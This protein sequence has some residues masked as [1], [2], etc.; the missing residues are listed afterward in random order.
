MTNLSC[1]AC[2]E[3]LMNLVKKFNAH[4]ILHPEDAANFVRVLSNL[5]GYLISNNLVYRID[6]IRKLIGDGVKW[7]GLL[8]ILLNQ[9]DEIFIYLYEPSLF[10]NFNEQVQ[11]AFNNEYSNVRIIAP[12]N[13]DE[14]DEIYSY[15]H[16]VLKLPIY[17]FLHNNLTS[18]WL[19]N[20]TFSPH[21][22]R[23]FYF[24]SNTNAV[25]YFE[26]I[27]KIAKNEDIKFFILKD[28]YDFDIPSVPYAITPLDKLDYYCS[29]Y[30]ERSQGISN[31]GGLLIQEFLETNNIIELNKSH[32]YMQIIPNSDLHYKTLIKPYE[33]GTFLNSIIE[34]TT[35]EPTHVSPQFIDILNAPIARFYPY[36]LSSIDYFIKNSHVHV[37]DINS[38]ARS[39]NNEKD[40]E[41]LPVDNILK[42]FINDVASEENEISINKQIEYQE[43]LLQLYQE[44]RKLGPAFI[45]GYRYISLTDEREFNIKEFC[46]EYV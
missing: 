16:N 39:L 23:S 9:Q 46:S 29:L 27:Q 19:L 10:K 7:T 32:F 28:E 14:T 3:A 44:V 24:P 35:E 43:N 21:T 25:D 34:N 41:K 37:I 12:L 4:E 20:F 33:E 13:L 11:K 30:Y 26:K 38:I 1:V 8:N 17:P 6:P 45:S 36:L 15:I 31:I 5:Q 2:D 18:K 40:L 42:N 22:L